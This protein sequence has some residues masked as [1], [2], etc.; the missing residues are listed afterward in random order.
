MLLTGSVSILKSM[1]KPFKDLAKECEAA[2]AIVYPYSEKDKEVIAMGKKFESLNEVK[3][4]EY[5]RVYSITEEV[6]FNGKKVDAFG[7]LTEYN[8]AVFGKARYLKGNR[9][10]AAKLKD[11]EC[12]IPACISNG[13]NIKVGD[14]I[15]IKFSTGEEEYKV[16]GIFAEPYNTSSSFECNILVNKLPKALTGKLYIK[17]YGKAGVD[18]SKIEEAY[19]EKY[20]RQMNG[21]FDTLENRI[22]NSLIA[23]NIVGAMFLAIG[24]IMLFVCCLVINFMIRNAMITDAKTIAIYKTMGYTSG[25]ILKMYLTFYFLLVSTACILGVLES[26]FLSNTILTSVFKNIGAVVSNNVLLP[27]GI[28]YVLIVTLVLGTIYLIIGKTKKVKPI[29]ALNGMSNSNTKKKKEYRGN[30]KIQFSAIGIALRTLLRNKKGAIGIILTAIVTIFSINF[31]VISL[32]VAYTMKENNDYWVG[33]DKS[34]VMIDVSDNYQFEKVEGIVKNDSRVNYYLNNSR[35]TT[36][37]MKWKKG[38]KSTF[39]YGYVFDDYS[40]SKLPVTRG[41]NPEAANEIAISSKVAGYVNKTVGDYIEVYLGGEKKVN[42]LITGLFQTYN[43][44]GD[45]CRLTKSV[46]TENNYPIKYD[47]ISIHLKD[48]KDINSFIEDIEGKVGKDGKVI[49]RTEA[50]SNIMNMIVAPQKSGIPPVVAVVL[51]VGAINIFCIVMLK[52]ASSEKTNVIYKAIGYSTVHLVLSNL[53]YVAIVAAASMAAAVPITIILY[54]HIMKAALSTFGFLEYPVS[55]NVLHII[56]A[57]LG[58]LLIFILSTL[59]SSRSL[60]KVNVRDLVQE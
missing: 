52:N 59:I 51:L 55:Y 6:T 31:A 5:T 30:S 37:T 38:M 26:V 2:T 9:N 32:D 53:Y 40:K 46:Y 4:V 10:T 34:D 14:R 28:C 8:D 57:N 56:L 33:V 13:N 17:L 49:P 29:Y 27:G 7:K 3:A 43:E 24:G 23:N 58:V 18:G 41:R 35:G 21:A 11:D 22:D 39:I 19:R 16:K 36:I 48:Q 47:S 1:E 15:K 45:Y 12:V 60:K 44:L 54:P 20:D 50:Y 25:D 42:L